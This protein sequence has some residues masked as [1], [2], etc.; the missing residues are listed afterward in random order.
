MNVLNRKAQPRANR[1]RIR[2]SPSIRSLCRFLVVPHI[3]VRCKYRCEHSRSQD[4]FNAFFIN[5][6]LSCSCCLGKVHKVPYA[7]AVILIF[8]TEE[9][10]RSSPADRCLVPGRL[11]LGSLSTSKGA[12]SSG[13]PSPHARIEHTH[14][15]SISS[16][17]L[18]DVIQLYK[19]VLMWQHTA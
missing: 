1:S 5:S 14:R 11:H 7:T 13:L 4:F 6:S 16:W 2:L 15:R 12:G 9:E 10:C 18:V 17:N 19:H 3:Q 8:C